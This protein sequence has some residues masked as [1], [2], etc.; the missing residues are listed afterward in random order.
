MFAPIQAFWDFVRDVDYPG[1]AAWSDLDAIRLAETY[2][3]PELWLFQGIYRFYFDLLAVR[4]FDADLRAAG[5]VSEGGG[6]TDAQE[7]K[8][9][10]IICS[11][12]AVTERFL[13]L[14]VEEEEESERVAA[15]LEDVKELESFSYVFQ[16]FDPVLWG[17][18]GIKECLLDTMAFARAAPWVTD[19]VRRDKIFGVDH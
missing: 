17:L 3:L 1:A 5:Q 16:D 11:G 7:Y 4:L 2:T 8:I 14:D 13:A 9:S 10:G 18:H 19:K 6:L 15:A 12:P